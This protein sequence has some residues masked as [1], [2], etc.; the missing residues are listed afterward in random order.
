[1]ARAYK[2]VTKYTSPNQNARKSK[3]TGC[4]VHWWGTPSG[5]NP[6]GVVSWL[7]ESAQV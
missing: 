2:Y 3:I 6:L 7:C 4:T 1:M 5:Q